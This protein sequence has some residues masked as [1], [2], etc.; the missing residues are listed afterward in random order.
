MAITDKLEDAK[1]SISEMMRKHDFKKANNDRKE[2]A[3]L[4]SSLAKCRG[5]LEICKKDFDRVIRT[6]ARN[7]REGQKEGIDTLIQEQMLWDAAIGY[8]LVRDAIFSLKTISN[9]DSVA[10]AYEMLEAAVKQ[11]AGK[12]GKLPK[13]PRIGLGK[14]RNA[15]GYI[16]SETALKDKEELLDSVFETLKA[17]GD[18]EDCLS[19]ARNPALRHAE[20]RNAY[21]G[22]TI[23]SDLSQAGGG[24]DLDEMM[25]R[26]NGV[27]EAPPAP[28]DYTDSLDSDMDIRPPEV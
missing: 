12:D 21:T 2:K 23:S 20:L 7:V 16:T 1:N 24:S 17:T 9:H 26:L 25:N 10:H 15:Y 28:I 4:Q 5:K 6:Q 3:E 27:D 8:M 13:F 14:E 19:A 11:M 18:I 22:G